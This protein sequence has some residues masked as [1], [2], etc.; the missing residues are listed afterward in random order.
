MVVLL[1]VCASGA[2]KPSLQTKQAKV[3]KKIKEVRHRIHLK[4]NEK[5][6]V[7]GQLAIVEEKLDDAQEK[8]NANTLRLEDASTVLDETIRRLVRAKRQLNRRQALL[9]R[10]IVDIYEGDDLN[11]IDVVLGSTN[12]WTFLSRAYYLQQ[13][14]RADTTLI[15]EVRALKASIEK[16]RAV[17]TQKIA[18]ISLLR[19]QLISER[20]QVKSLASSKERQIDAIEHDAA[21]MEQALSELEQ[22]SRQIEDQIRRIQNTPAGIKRSAQVFRGGLMFPCSGRVSSRYGYRVHPITRVYKLHT[23]VDIS[24]RTG[25]PIHAAANGTVIVAGWMKAYGYA[26]VIDHGGRVSTLYGHN[27][28]LLVSVGDEVKQGQV[29]AKAG[30]T[31]YSTGSHCHFEKRVNGVPVNPGCP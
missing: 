29:I 18:E 27:S 22:E 28:R 3:Q 12:M 17:Q 2:K 14:L 9:Q 20:N 19:G 23:G 5:R 1:R 13:I 6:T 16:D 4:E 11:Y 21:L 15:S 10:R 30:S 24:V 8:L 7:T 31:G 25:T 26:V